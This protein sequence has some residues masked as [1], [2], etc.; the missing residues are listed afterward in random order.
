M[1][2]GDVG[3][4][5]AKPRLYTLSIA[6]PGSVVDNAQSRELKTCLVGQIARAA[7]IYQVD[8]IVVYDDM[9]GA[10][11]PAGGVPVPA[12]GGG[13]SDP[14]VFM[15]RLL[16]Y[17]ET[18]QYLRRP[19]FPMHPDLRFAGLLAPLDAPHH[20]RV[21]E[22]APFREGVVIEGKPPASAGG[23]IGNGSL[24][25]IGLRRPA[26]IDRAI[27]PG[28]RVTVR[29]VHTSPAQRG[30]PAG[31]AVAPSTP[32]T[33]LGLYWGYTTRLA[34]SLSDVTA[35]CPFPGGYDL[36]VGTSERGTASVDDPN[37]KLPTF[38]HAL[39]VFGGVAGIEASVDA[40][41][42]SALAGENAS[43]LFDLWVNT[44]P[45]QGSRT[46]RTEEA[47]LLS[48]ARLRPAVARN[49]PPP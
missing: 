11:R 29:L 48:L 28:V 1:A 22:A 44:C 32:R 6:V 25:N 31:S 24:V 46:I 37:F 43:S 40:D 16:Q 20:V 30:H 38:R 33:E 36:T 8:E 10:A 47:V 4:A 9:M 5:A 26:V 23:G 13:S 17:L 41:E 12:A 3:G 35:E 18:P 45:E 21:D 15:A 2:G 7:A 49:V 42:T 19:L 27:R 14:N 39:I 34:A